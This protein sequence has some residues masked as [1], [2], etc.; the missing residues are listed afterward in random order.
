MKVNK[1]AIIT[2]AGGSIGSKSAKVL[3]GLGLSC[4]LIDVRKENA[5]ATKQQLK[6]NINH[7]VL[8]ADVSTASGVDNVVN[9]VMTE[10][11]RIDVLVNLAASNRKSFNINAL[12][13]R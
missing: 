12:V 6:D 13:S 5:E 2:G 1:V 3:S 4:A 9:K 7:M 11:G 8:I 10:W